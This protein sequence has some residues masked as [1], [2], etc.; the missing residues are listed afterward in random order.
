MASVAF[1]LRPVAES[2]IPYFQQALTDPCV[3]RFM[4]VKFTT[5]APGREQWDWYVSEMT[6][7]TGYF[8]AVELAAPS[9]FAGVL[10]MSGYQAD[11][12][13]G[14]LGYWFLPE[15]WGK[16][17]AKAALPLFIA[18]LHQK[19]D[20]HR[21]TANIENDHHASRALL[22]HIGFSSEG[23]QRD[24]ERKEDRWIQLEHFGKLF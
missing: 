20:L 12:K 1:H 10:S 23:I 21:L 7:A 24:T 9:T 18:Q 8:M 22:L 6:A 4:G 2:D 19:F 13:C 5:D 3:L 11:N 16:G 14:E 15:F 17:L